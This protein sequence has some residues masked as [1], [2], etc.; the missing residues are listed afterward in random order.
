MA[1]ISEATM[2]GLGPSAK[3]IDPIIVNYVVNVLKVSVL[4]CISV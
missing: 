2:D 4:T 3:E 1:T